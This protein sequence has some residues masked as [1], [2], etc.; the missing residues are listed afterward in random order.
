MSKSKL[1]A[2]VRKSRSVIFR[3]TQMEM[4]RVRGAVRRSG[5]YSV[6]EWVRDVVLAA[7]GR[8]R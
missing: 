6:S 3:V 1:P 4:A 5:K 2:R 8:G 7:A